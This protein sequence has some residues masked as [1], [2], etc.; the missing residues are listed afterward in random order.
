MFTQ[1]CL[2]RS[3]RTFEHLESCCIY[4]R[5]A[6]QKSSERVVAA[7]MLK[8]NFSPVL[9]GRRLCRLCRFVP[10]H[11]YLPCLVWCGTGFCYEQATLLRT[12]CSL[13]FALPSFDHQ[14]KKNETD[15][16]LSA[17]AHAISQ[18]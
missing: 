10:C 3:Y 15:I 6:Q 13:T 5:F 17:L 7:G 8:R 18:T 4:S 2:Q 9:L 1:W 16:V 11:F 12:R 14:V